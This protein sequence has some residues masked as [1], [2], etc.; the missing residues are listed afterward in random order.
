MLRVGDVCS[1]GCGLGI[2][3]VG[4]VAGQQLGPEKGS[5]TYIMCEENR[6]SAGTW[7]YAM[8][9]P[10]LVNPPTWPCVGGGGPD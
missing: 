1:W 5:G 7:R 3:E 4:R 6:Y 8:R 9:S 10:R 2:R